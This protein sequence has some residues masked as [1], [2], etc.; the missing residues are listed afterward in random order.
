MTQEPPI[1]AVIFD[2]DGT[3]ANT[4]PVCIAAFQV[5]FQQYTGRWYTSD[6]IH[7]L[8]GPSEDGIMQKVIGERWQDA[9]A[10]YLREYEKAHSR[11]TQPFDGITQLLNW[12]D[13]EGIETA[14]VTGKGAGS[15]EISLRRIGL[16]DA[17]DLVET[18][19]PEGVQKPA[20]IAKVLS[21]WGIAPGET[22]YVGDAPSD[23]TS[24]RQAEVIPIAAAWAPKSDRAKLEDMHPAACFNAV[25]D[26]VE[27]LK[28][29]SQ[30]VAKAN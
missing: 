11:C 14:V 28:P 12:L 30:S 6:D 13:A 15:A 23:V 4:L 2:L 16:T 20:S 17:F 9:L 8:F 5:A 26:L 7:A 22:V 10:T 21:I 24:A 19:S 18:G 3:L 29:R 1:K 25:G 27:W